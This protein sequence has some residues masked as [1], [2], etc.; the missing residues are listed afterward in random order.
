MQFSWWKNPV[1][2]TNATFWR[3]R[4]P[5]GKKTGIPASGFVAMSWNVWGSN[6]PIK[7]I[8]V[9]TSQINQARNVSIDLHQNPKSAQNSIHIPPYFCSASGILLPSEPSIDKFI[10]CRVFLSQKVKTIFRPIV[11]G[12]SE[13]MH[14]LDLAA[15]ITSWLGFE[16]MRE[17]RCQHGGSGLLGRRGRRGGSGGGA[18]L[19]ATNNILL[20]GATQW[21][22]PPSK[23]T[24]RLE[25]LLVACVK[26]VILSV[27][28]RGKYFGGDLKEI[29]S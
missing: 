28:G 29:C 18:L 9:L 14:R 7:V 11:F 21:T 8:A 22:Q 23:Q 19:E 20:I 25:K 24:N 6:Q 10:S 4:S 15:A 13:K 1:G 5:V 26:C 12:M 27:M 2:N 16:R 3:N 17:W